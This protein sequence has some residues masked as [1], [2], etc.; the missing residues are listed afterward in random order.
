VQDV[1]LA[2]VA[3]HVR[4]PLPKMP[5]SA[6]AVTSAEVASERF[7]HQMLAGSPSHG[8]ESHGAEQG[9]D[10]N[11]SFRVGTRIMQRVVQKV[12]AE[13]RKRDKKG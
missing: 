5:E 4:Y 12:G 2:E 3:L 10:E 6:L 11:R 9:A 7:A 8:R 1:Y 13:K